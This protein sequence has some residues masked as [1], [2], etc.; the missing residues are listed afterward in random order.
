MRQSRTSSSGPGMQGSANEAF[1]RGIKQLYGMVATSIRGG[2]S[3]WLPVLEIRAEKASI[4]HPCEGCD[5]S[6]VSDG[7]WI[8]T[9]LRS[10]HPG[11]A[12][13]CLPRQ[14]REVD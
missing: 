6:P 8:E 14:R 9:E 2:P 13:R 11:A 1:P 5:A 12:R 10:V 4:T 3:G 7:R